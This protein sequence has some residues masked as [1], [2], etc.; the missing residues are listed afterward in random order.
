MKILIPARKGSKGFPLKNRKLLKYTLK[1]I[2]KEFY[3]DVFVSTDDEHIKEALPSGVTV[4][5]R[6]DEVS[7][8]TSSTHSTVSEFVESFDVAGEDIIMLYLT[9]PDRKWE[10]VQDAYNKYKLLRASSL[11]CKKSVDVHPFLMMYELDENRGRQIAEH[12]LY[13]R[14][15]YPACFEISHYISIFKEEELK[16]LNNSMYNKNT[17]FY[18]IGD[19]IDVDYEEDLKKVSLWL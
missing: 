1:T 15:D 2:P 19:V 16:K 5:H 9:Y 7:S 3:S 10:H 8:D 17:Y 18:E 12:N 14:Q 4:H 13:R 11:L 6:S